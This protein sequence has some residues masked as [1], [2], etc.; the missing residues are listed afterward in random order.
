MY[1]VDLYKDWVPFCNVSKTVPFF[2]QIKTVT[3]SEKVA[4]FSV[5]IPLF[6]TRE[7][8]FQGFGVADI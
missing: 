5:S 2:T 3:R 8:Y 7:A 4:L 1:E 6:A